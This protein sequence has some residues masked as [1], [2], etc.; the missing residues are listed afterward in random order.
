ML[1][2]I[3]LHLYPNFVYLFSPVLEKFYLIKTN[4]K[5]M[6]TLLYCLL[7]EINNSSFREKVR[8]F[9]KMYGSPSQL[10]LQKND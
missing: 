8:Y 1:S 2:I 5:I 10:S 4:L 6:I 9:L 3:N 7:S